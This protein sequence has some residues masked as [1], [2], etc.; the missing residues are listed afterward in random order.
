MSRK[1]FKVATAENGVTPTQDK[2]HSF[3]T[4]KKDNTPTGKVKDLKSKNDL[5]KEREEQY[6]KFRIAALTRRCK[7][8]KMTEEE[9]AKKVKELTEL[10]DTPNQYSVLIFFNPNNRDMVV[11]ALKNEDIVYNILSKDYG[12]ID[13]DKETLDTLR[14]ILPPGTKIHPYTKKKK[15]VLEPQVKARGEKK[16]TKADKKRLANMAKA[17]RKKA[18]NNLKELTK[19]RKRANAAGL[20]KE[21]RKKFF[22]KVKAIKASW[23]GQ[24]KQSGTVVHL[25]AKKSSKGLKTALKKAA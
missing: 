2:K 13:A 20:S 4:V 6:K 3:I 25:K 23:K 22:D 18:N 12:Y 5:Q 17:A 15:P 21:E 19:Y 24:K 7:R 16:R 10:L 11:Q 1:N 9:I 8:M 14:K